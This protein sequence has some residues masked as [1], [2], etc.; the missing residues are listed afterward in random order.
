MP[1]MNTAFV[2]S[3]EESQSISEI[4][5]N[6]GPTC[7]PHVINNVFLYMSMTPLK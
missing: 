7:D 6:N 5:V 2:S 4:N 3:T 1:I